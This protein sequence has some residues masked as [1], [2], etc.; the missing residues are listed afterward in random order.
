L[1]S[2]GGSKQQED[3]ANISAAYIVGINQV[4]QSI[5]CLCAVGNDAWIIN[6]GASE[7]MCSEGTVLHDL[8]SLQQPVLVNLPNGSR[9]KVTKH[10]KLRISKDLVLSRVL[11][12]PNFKFNLL[13]V[14]RLCE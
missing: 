6:S 2:S 8:C 14:R 11:H 12:V 5:H 9:V 3:E 10:G 1:T 4:L 13:S 7:H